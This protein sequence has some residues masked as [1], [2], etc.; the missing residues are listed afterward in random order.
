MSNS[1]LIMGESGTGKSTSIRTLDSKETFVINVLKKPLPFKGF[2]KNYVL[3]TR[4]NPNGNLYESDNA[5]NIIKTINYISKNRPDIKN[6]IIDDFQYIMAN[7]FMRKAREKGF[8]KFT[9][10]GQQGWSVARECTEAR[11]D[12]YFFILSHTETDSLGRSKCKT[13]GKML[14]EKIT[15]EG[16]FTV[17]LH[18]LIVDNGYKFLTQND[19]SHIAKSPMDM[20]DRALIDN[21]LASIKE[22]MVEYYAGEDPNFDDSGIV[23]SI[24]HTV[25]D[26]IAKIEEQVNIEELKKTFKNAQ[27][28]LKHVLS[29]DILNRIISAKEN[30][31]TKLMLHAQ[32]GVTI[33]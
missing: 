26:W 30:Q 11:D 14:D 23:N 32:T 10:I 28:D 21:D 7:E 24:E 6:V 15:L 19:G 20:F 12:L 1:I 2:R 3:A 5:A 25:A 4:E 29:E 27:D 18:S 16:M 9:E 22:K 31:Q 8:D 17:V 13:I 33:Q